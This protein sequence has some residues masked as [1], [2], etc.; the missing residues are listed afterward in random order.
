MDI[1]CDDGK[2]CTL[3]YEFLASCT[4]FVKDD[5]H[6]NCQVPCH[7]EFCKKETHFY[8]ECPVYFC[9]LEPNA[10]TTTSTT[11]STTWT[12]TRPAPGPSPRPGPP[13]P[14]SGGYATS[15]TFNFIF[16][17]AALVFI[18]LRIRNRRQQDRSE[19]PI[20]RR[21]QGL[22]N[23]LYRE[24]SEPLLA[25]ISFRRGQRG[26]QRQAAEVERLGL[27]NLDAAA[28][29]FLDPAEPER[30][31]ISGETLS[32]LA[33]IDLEATTQPH[34][35]SGMQLILSRFRRNQNHEAETTF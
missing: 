13:H 7:M 23:P 24:E 21:S 31:Q 15:V 28:A 35:L 4:I 32:D 33:E 22:S 3:T 25:R 8:I 2:V 12:T 17:I 27:Q 30:N 6:A 19:P 11:T 16:V 5:A 1:R 26:G 14:S 9:S 10:T 20:I 29:R 34:R 18:A